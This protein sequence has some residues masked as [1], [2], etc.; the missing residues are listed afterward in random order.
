MR[1]VICLNV[2]SFFALHVICDLFE[3][4]FIFALHV[5]CDFFAFVV[6]NDFE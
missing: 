2:F 6:I 4:V 5:I 3:C 1:F